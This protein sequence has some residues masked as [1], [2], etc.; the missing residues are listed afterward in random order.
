M[1]RMYGRGCWNPTPSQ[2][3]HPG[4]KA[5][6]PCRV[7]MICNE[8]SR[9]RKKPMQLRVSVRLRQPLCEEQTWLTKALEN[10]ASS[11]DGSRCHPVEFDYA[12][13]SVRK[14]NGTSRSSAPHVISRISDKD[15]GSMSHVRLS[16]DPFAHWRLGP[17]GSRSTCRLRMKY[18]GNP[19]NVAANHFSRLF[20]LHDHPSHPND[21]HFNRSHP[22]Q[23]EIDIS[24]IE[25]S[26][27]S[28]RIC[29]YR[30]I[31]GMRPES[32]ARS[33]EETF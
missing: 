17:A 4:A 6:A 23:T 26:L 12:R 31:K 28:P 8:F 29:R 16:N 11:F 5:I 18:Q 9:A 30:V 7:K 10:P 24:P 13:N 3:S 21:V 15:H 25:L 27:A 33:K 20:S 32:P 14:H 19:E 22:Q 2:S 1:N